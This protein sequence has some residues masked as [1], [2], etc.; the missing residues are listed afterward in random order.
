MPLVTLAQLQSRVYTRLDQNTLLYTQQNVTDAINECIRVVNLATGFLQITAQVPNLSQSNRVFYDVPAG[1]L[2]PM[3]VQFESGYLTKYFP[4]AIG[5]SYATWTQDNTANTG[6]PVSEWIP[7]GFSKFAIHPADSIGGSPIF[8]TGIAEPVQ[9][10]NQSDT[11]LIPV[12][13]SDCIINLAAQILCLKE[14]GALFKQSSLYYQQYL[15]LM[16]KLTIWRGM[17]MPRYYVE[18]TQKA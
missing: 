7:T 16:K 10:V 18:T 4:N 13:Y 5:M 6:L 12:E 9:L 2:V 3:R 8:V 14:T 17:I 1:I 15:S 11:T